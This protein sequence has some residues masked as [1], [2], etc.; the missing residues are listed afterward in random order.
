VTDN[1]F[2]RAVYCIIG[3][4]DARDD[5]PEVANS[6]DDYLW[7]KLGQVAFDDSDPA[8]ER[9]S[10]VQLQTMLLEEFGVYS[11]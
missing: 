5:H 10:L 1:Y 8:R 9:L 6:T 3:R 4:C 7:L 11:F 2:R